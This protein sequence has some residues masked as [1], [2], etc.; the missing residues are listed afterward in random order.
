MESMEIDGEKKK[1]IASLIEY[2]DWLED[3][4]IKE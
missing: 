1:I 3:T 4:V 2:G